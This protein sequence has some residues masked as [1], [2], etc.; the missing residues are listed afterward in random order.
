M[1]A[2]ARLRL[3]FGPLLGRLP[4]ARNLLGVPGIQGRARPRVSLLI[5]AGR[6]MKFFA[7]FAALAIAVSAQE[8]PVVELPPLGAQP[9]PPQQQPPPPQ[10]QKP[11][12]PTIGQVADTMMQAAIDDLHSQLNAVKEEDEPDRLKQAYLNFNLGVN[13][14]RLGRDEMARQHYLAADDLGSDSPEIR[15]RA[16]QN[17]GVMKHAEA[18]T[19]SMEDPDEAL[20]LLAQAQKRYREAMALDRHVEGVAENTERALT[21]RRI[22]KQVKEMQD[23]MQEKVD[24]AQDKTEEAH[25]AQEEANQAS[26]EDK[27]QKQKE[28]QEKTEAAEE[29]MQE[30]ADEARKQGMEEAAEQVE[31]AKENVSKA[32]K[33][34]EDAMAQQEGSEQRQKS[35]EEAEDALNE[36]MSQIGVKPDPPEGE[37]GE[38]QE[39]MAGKEGEDEGEDDGEGEG[40]GEQEGEIAAPSEEEPEGEEE[41]QVAI[42]EPGEEDEEDFDKMSALARLQAIQENEK[43]FKEHL[44]AEKMQKRARQGQVPK[45]W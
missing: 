29:A 6:R 37:E 24:D 25:E 13:Y 40:E 1:A 26:N 4:A 11:Q 12:Q 2:P 3:E 39:G 38:P 34:Q 19:K 15:A 14:Q 20:K 36:A 7:I 28:A 5:Q 22:M 21:E 9:P 33:A 16:K 23:A 42:G 27:Q 32:Q 17:L 31:Q 10:Q 44:K 43:D 30:L 45:N 35:E 18:R 8:A 41:E